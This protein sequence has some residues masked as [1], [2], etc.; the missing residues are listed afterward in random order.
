MEG[1]ENLGATGFMVM[2]EEIAL[3]EVEDE[4]LPRPM[5]GRK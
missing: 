2:V 4:Q 3:L 5:S 1:V